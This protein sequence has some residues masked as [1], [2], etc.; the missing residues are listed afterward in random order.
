M[1]KMCIVKLCI[2]MIM[3]IWSPLAPCPS[4]FFS[5]HVQKHRW[6]ECWNT[7]FVIL[8]S[9][10]V[11]YLFHEQQTSYRTKNV[12]GTQGGHCGDHFRII[13]INHYPIRKKISSEFEFN[14]FAIGK[15]VKIRSA[16]YFIFR[17]DLKMRHPLILQRDPP[18]LAQLYSFS[19]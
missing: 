10:V 17:L 7:S 9:V 14:Y 2:P 18:K 12:S 13:L 16:Y 11:S 15:L 19:Y 5:F 8:N 4:T 6:R 1:T 3:E